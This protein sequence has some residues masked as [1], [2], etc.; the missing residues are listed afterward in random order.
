ML[1]GGDSVTQKVLIIDDDL[2]GQR[3]M[4]Y[5]L[6]RE[7]YEIVLAHDGP[8]G[9]EKAMTEQPDV[10]ILDV[11]MPGMDGYEVCR[12]LRATPST[13]DLPVLMLTAKTQLTD[14][15][16]GFRAGA[17][18]YVAKPAEPAEV[19][20]RIKALLARV[21]RTLP[22]A[23]RSIAILGAK[24]GVGTTTIAVNLAVAVAQREQQ[25]I[26]VDMRPHMG[27][28]AYQLGLTRRTTL[29]D[30]LL[31]D[32]VSIDQKALSSALVLHQ[33]GFRVLM[34][35]PEPGRHQVISPSQVQ[36]IVEG[37]RSLASLL[38]FDLPAG[39]SEANAAVLRACDLIAII[40]EPEPLS[41]ACARDV[42]RLLEKQN[43]SNDIV[44]IL[45]CNRSRSTNSV[46]PVE[47]ASFLD[48]RLLG[49]IPPA[50]EAC[51]EANRQGLPL[52]LTPS[53]EVVNMAF[54]DLA[55]R[56]M[57]HRVPM[58]GFG[59]YMPARATG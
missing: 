50:P 24:G 44:G 9:V 56:I 29:A 1:P 34:S 7:G 30:L 38:I 31:L 22:Q 15:V 18:D 28:V 20:A 16:S 3:L 5:T 46:A 36:V 13:A 49:S 40:T 57:A 21:R 2:A 58:Q 17:D 37:L 4:E 42:V 48:R 53:A 55:E 52:I 45:I 59:L 39:F 14:K 51:F 26:L 33:A 54:R 27:T 11:M 6:R 23:G 41:L 32:E 10:V 19:L 25:V 12:Q 43:I 35:A 47:V 8:Q